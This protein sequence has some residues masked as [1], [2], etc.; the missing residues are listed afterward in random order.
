[1]Y[2]F[3]TERVRR[4]LHI[5]L[6]MSP[7]GDAFRNRLRMFPSLISCCTIDWFQVW[8]SILYLL[9]ESYISTSKCKNRSVSQIK[10][11]YIPA[12][13]VQCVREFRFLMVVGRLMINQLT[14][15]VLIVS[16]LLRSHIKHYKVNDCW[17]RL[18]IST[19]IDHRFV[20]REWIKNTY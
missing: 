10:H 7:I 1:M 15:T 19:N 18:N 4:N 8:R 6:A 3:F 11:W 13:A 20:L 14:V 17:A 9:E 12:A 5:V 16:F 2:N